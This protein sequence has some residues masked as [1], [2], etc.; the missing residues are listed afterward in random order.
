[1]HF[2]LRLIPA[3]TA[4]VLLVACGGGSNSPLTAASYT[5]TSGIAVDGYLRFS[6]VVCDTN[7]NGA[8]DATEPIVYTLGSS[9]DS[10]KFTFPQG[11]ANHALFV[12]EGTNADSGLMFTGMLMAPAGATVVS[13]LTTLMAAGMTL[14]QLTSAL[15]PLGSDPLHT[16]PLAQTDLIPYKKALAVQQLLQKTTELFAGLGSVVGSAAILPIYSEVVKAFAATLKA[17]A[18]PLFTSAT[19]VKTAVVDAIVRAAVTKVLSATTVMPEVKT[20]LSAYGGAA[21]LAPI[22]A[23]S[24]AFQATSLLTA[25][26]VTQAALANQ[27]NGYITYFVKQTVDPAALPTNPAEVATALLKQVSAGAQVPSA[28]PG[29]ISFSEAG[30]S[31]LAFGDD[32]GGYAAVAND[33]TNAAN[34]VLQI[35][36]KPGDQVYLGAIVDTSGNGA[37]TVTPPVALTSTNRTLS[38]RVYS[39]AIGEKILLKLEQGP[40]GAQQEVLATTTKANAWETLTFT[41][42]NAGTYAQVDVM[43]H[44]GTAVTSATSFYFD[45]LNLIPTGTPA[46]PL[47]ASM[48]F[49]ASTVV[50]QAFGDKGG[51]YAVIDADPTD[52]AN[53][54]LKMVKKSGDEVFFGATVDTTEQVVLT[55]TQKTFTLRVYSPAIGEKVLLKLAQG[56]NGAANTEVQATTTKANAWETLTF[57][58][59]GTGTYKE[60][61]IFPHFNTAVTADTTFYFDDLLFTNTVPVVPSGPTDFLSVA[62]NAISLTDRGVTTP[63]PLATFQTTPGVSV[64]WPLSSPATLNVTLAQVGNFNFAS[65]QTLKAAVQITETGGGL[66]K[67]MAYIDNVS[68]SK[69]V[70]GGIT[71]SVPMTGATAKVYGVSTD[72]AKKAVIDFSNSV[73]NVTNTLSL[74]TANSILFGDMVNYAINKVSNDF[75]GIT[76][77]RGTY[78]VT[79][80]VSDLPLKKAD[81]TAFT[82]LTIS[83]PTA[84]D[85]VTKLP[86][87]PVSV[88]G[89]GLE[90]YI[91][92]TN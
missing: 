32:G 46:L 13:P 53:K 35:V 7:D 89:F 59:P 54:V 6:K 62:N 57:V 56:I 36:K 84:I 77:L 39:P 76:G 16:D 49:A 60:I 64:K 4:A 80:V 38:M 69:S 78:K 24:L 20:A 72:G 67:V 47:F 90:G 29:T 22:T 87:A 25:V 65:N 1:M 17:S 8:P 28:P 66:G 55:S 58:F 73:K 3:A 48:D 71:L 37:K 70:S 52:A 21:I 85:A 61:D 83:V 34:K 42:N 51:G 2:K 82:P 33:P 27:S 91:T 26:D 43:P 75:T 10:G 86:A 15:G 5:P 30:L 79:I 74:T 44:F 45:D 92:L 14:D 11:C 68:V 23:G 50:I 12:T 40:S 31:L 41:F 88:T 9:A 81:G 18:V 63:L 19:E